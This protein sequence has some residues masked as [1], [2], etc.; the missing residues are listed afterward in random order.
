MIY[1]GVRKGSNEHKQHV[2]VKVSK[3]ACGYTHADDDD[4]DDDDDDGF[5]QGVNT[6]PPKGH[7]DVLS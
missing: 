6:R 7:A 5:R 2:A 4:D 3:Y 1:H